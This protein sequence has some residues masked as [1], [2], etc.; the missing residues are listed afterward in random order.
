M[1]FN[2]FYAHTKA[3]TILGAKELQN[4]CRT[5]PLVINANSDTRVVIK[6]AKIS[7]IIRARTEYLIELTL[8]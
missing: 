4:V 5:W 3:P 7:L 1:D 2:Q 8:H 6:M